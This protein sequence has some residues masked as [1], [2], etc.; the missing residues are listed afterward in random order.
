MIDL[1]AAI[2][3]ANNFGKIDTCKFQSSQKYE[4]RMQ[5]DF[6]EAC[7]QAEVCS[8]MLSDRF[9]LFSSSLHMKTLSHSFEHLLCATMFLVRPHL[10]FVRKRRL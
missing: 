4:S 9:S 7:H 3:L 10:E 5:A 2:F 1:L 6:S 8:V